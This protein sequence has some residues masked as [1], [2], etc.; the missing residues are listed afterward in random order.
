MGGCQ[1]N[2]LNNMELF[3]LMNISSDRY[4]RAIVDCIGIEDLLTYRIPEDINIRQ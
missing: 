1:K 3:D 4:V 2:L